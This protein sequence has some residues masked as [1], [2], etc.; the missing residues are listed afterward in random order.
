MGARY[1]ELTR[2]ELTPEQAKV[3]DG[4]AGHRK[5]RMPS[6]FHVLLTSPEL[7]SL[8]QEVGA[9]CRYRTGL[10]PRLSEV[11]ILT[12]ASH[13]KCAYELAVHIPE[14]RNGGV[15][16]HEIEALA[17]GRRPEFA[18]KDAALVHA[19]A[20]ELLQ[21][22][23]VSETTY[24]AAVARFGA[25]TTVE[26]SG[27]IGYYTLLALVMLAARVEAPSKP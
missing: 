4:V 1:K 23:D 24:N 16:A 20:T 19:F 13:W 17:E 10:P 18:D 27:I 5:G 9:F 15:P 26:L 22:R 7:C 3:W 6:P 2:E 8:V 25:Q 14:A 12:V 11:A 21:N